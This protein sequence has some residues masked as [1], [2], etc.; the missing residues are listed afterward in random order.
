[1]ERFGVDLR[2]SFHDSSLECYQNWWVYFVCVPFFALQLSSHSLCIPRRS[3]V[4][5]LY[6]NVLCPFG[7]GLR[8]IY[9]QLLRPVVQGAWTHVLQPLWDTLCYWGGQLLR[10]VR[11]IGRAIR[12]GYEAVRAVVV[13]VRDAVRT[14]LT[15]VRDAVRGAWNWLL[16]H[17]VRAV[18][19]QLQALG[20]ALRDGLRWVW[21]NTFVR[22]YD[23]LRRA[24]R[25]V[26]VEVL[27]A[28][29]RAAQRAVEWVWQNVIVAAARAVRRAVSYVWQHSVQRALQ[30]V[31][32]GLRQIG[33]AMRLCGTR[34]NT[35]LQ[36]VW[37]EV[38]V[39]VVYDRLLVPVARAVQR[40]ASAADRLLQAA[41]N[42]SAN[43][44]HTLFVVWLWDSAL[45]PAARAVRSALHHV[46]V[47][48]V[49]RGLI[50][51]A[52]DAAVRLW[53]QTVVR[54]YRALQRLY[55]ACVQRLSDAYNACMQ[56]LSDAYTACMQRLTNAYNAV[57]RAVRRVYDRCVLA[58][59]NALRWVWQTCVLTPLRALRRA[60]ERVWQAL[61]IDPAR[62]VAR[63]V[64][65]V[66]QAFA[67]RVRALY[68]A[69]CK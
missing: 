26:W 22:A 48:W 37:R 27:V 12:S 3:A 32:E 24:V 53:N 6:D 35:A 68:H 49:W 28:S 16:D 59:Q 13:R 42:R 31:R 44:L 4:T 36:W 5:W 52:R 34:L 17:T 60:A 67:E 9:T 38:L 50:L 66:W 47:E 46:V 63:A 10:A 57:A 23:A 62:A 69:F 7:R 15:R 11:A 56:R 41:Y 58:V 45:V 19:R 8:Y 54:A 30:W 14:A 20:R 1:V 18:W 25:W 29:A 51:R 61:V 21:R 33:L 39:R 64:A 43:A 40:A 65:R 55:T 2:E